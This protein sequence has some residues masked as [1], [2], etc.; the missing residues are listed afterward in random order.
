MEDLEDANEDGNGANANSVQG[1]VTTTRRRRRRKWRSIAIFLLLLI[2]DD[3]VEGVGKVTKVRE[4][5]ATRVAKTAKR[6]AT[7]DGK[8]HCLSILKKDVGAWC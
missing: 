5:T 2:G 4:R 8:A 7:T 6:T 3:E 1:Q